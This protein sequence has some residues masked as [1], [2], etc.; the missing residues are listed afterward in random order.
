MFFFVFA[1]A[2][3]GVDLRTTI[4]A[5][6]GALVYTSG[7][8]S[9]T[10]KNLGN[11]H[12]NNV[13]LVIELPETHTSPNVYVMGTVGAIPSSC[14]P[15]GTTL[16]CALGQI[17]ANK[18]KVVAVSLELPYSTAPLVVG[19]ISNT[20]GVVDTNP[21]NNTAAVAA[22]LS[23]PSISFVPDRDVLAENC[24]GTGLTSFYECVV[25]PGSTQ[26]H[27]A[28]YHADGSIS[29]P[30]SADYGGSW[31]QPTLQ[32]LHF[33]YTELG[34]VVMTFD[35]VAVDAACWEGVILS[36]G[37]TIPYSVCLN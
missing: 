2:F 35:G 21:A 11:T 4:T 3:A 22:A 37:Y 8:W 16:V 23:Y 12:A 6:A 33:D 25:S 36:G 14:V 34:Q 20:P 5:P 10:V 7:S 28:T 15:S 31:S 26:S 19:A 27:D 29:F 30:W 13:E 18:S 24:T 1:P 32:T 9:V 17:K